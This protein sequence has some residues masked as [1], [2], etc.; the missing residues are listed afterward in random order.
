MRLNNE[1]TPRSSI[2]YYTVNQLLLS[3]ILSL[4]NL[5]KVALQ[6]LQG[7]YFQYNALF[8]KKTVLQF[9]KR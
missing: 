8:D 6:K 7:K 1:D 3:L 4:L 9:P 5:D 2:S